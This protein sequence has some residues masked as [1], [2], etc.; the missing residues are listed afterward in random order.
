MASSV[1]QTMIR[2]ADHR[3]AAF[4]GMALFRSAARE[5]ARP[6]A[7]QGC[8]RMTKLH[9]RSLRQRIADGQRERPHARRAFVTPEQRAPDRATAPAL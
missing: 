7:G 3:K 2:K 5:K 6:T 8:S 4:S 1:A 9:Q